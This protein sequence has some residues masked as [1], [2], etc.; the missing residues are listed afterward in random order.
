VGGESRDEP[1]SQVFPVFDHATSCELYGDVR[2][3][4]GLDRGASYAKKF[5]GKILV[6]GDQETGSSGLKWDRIR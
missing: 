5:G 1:N 4:G 6:Y 3:A 2:G